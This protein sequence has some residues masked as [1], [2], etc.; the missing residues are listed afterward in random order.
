MVV[1]GVLIG[2]NT[3]LDEPPPGMGLTT[4]TEAVEAVA[5]SDARIVTVSCELLTKF[6]ARGLPFQFTIEPETNPV[7]FT[8]RVNPA[9]PGAAASGTNGWLTKG[10]GFC[11]VA[12]VANNAR[13]LKVAMKRAT[14]LKLWILRAK[15][16]VIGNL[17]RTHGR[18]LTLILT[19]TIDHYYTP[20]PVA[21]MMNGLRIRRRLALQER[22]RERKK[23][24]ILRTWSLP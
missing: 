24:R 14:N 20:Q 9:P 7:P 16:R 13:V 2:K 10:T 15:R 12:G 17:R 8:V 22:R 21:V 23:K 6:V 1:A 19:I 5:M 3:I 11:P 4:V 18:N